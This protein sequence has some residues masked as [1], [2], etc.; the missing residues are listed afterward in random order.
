MP[1]LTFKEQLA[2]IPEGCGLSDSNPCQNNGVYC[3]KVIFLS[4]KTV[5]VKLRLTYMPAIVHKI[6]LENFA[7]NL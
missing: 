5:N 4:N 6:S 7:K 2:Q 3:I 1:D